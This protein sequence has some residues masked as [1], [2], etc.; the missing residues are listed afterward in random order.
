LIEKPETRTGYRIVLKDE[1]A[2]FGLVSEGLPNDEHLVLC[3]WYGDFLS[4]FQGM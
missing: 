1:E 4:T 2:M 3:G